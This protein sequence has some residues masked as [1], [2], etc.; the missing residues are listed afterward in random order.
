MA[1]RVWAHHRLFL[2]V[3]IPAV[4]LR[5]DAELG[6][7]WQAWF[8]DSFE[9]VSNTVSFSLDPTR[10]SGYEIW[11]KILQPLH[12]Y[13]VITILQHLMG[14]AIGVMIY[15]LARHRF[16]APPWLAML[17]AVPVLYDGFEIELEHLIL[18][19]LPFLF[20]VTLAVTLL[21]WNPAGPSTRMCLLIGGLLGLSVILRSVGEPLVAVFI[22][23]MIIRRFSWRKISGRHRG[24]R[25][26]HPG[27]RRAVRPGAR[28]VRHGRRH[29]RVPVL[30]GDDVRRLQRH[31]PARQRAVAVHHGAAG[32]AADRP[33]LHLDLPDA[34]GP[35]APTKFEPLPNKLAEN[36]A[37]RAIKAQPVPYA[38]AV[39]SDTLKVFAWNRAGLPE[40]ADLQRVP[41]PAHADADPD[42]GQ[43]EDRA[44]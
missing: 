30:A 32:Q 14:L 8:N 28:R 38:K 25:G 41:V 18:S 23:Y 39:V 6:Y 11:L 29:R 36:F 12:S 20:L 24:V 21:L 15:A 42:L 9:Y 10:V 44:V 37:I 35:A 27:L 17:A 26:A 7:R 19:D 2:I 31:P 33:G 16:G 34:A 40:R 13:A 4:L 1:A 5:A 3:M 43:G 22:V